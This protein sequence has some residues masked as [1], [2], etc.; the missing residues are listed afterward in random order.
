[1]KL[2]N[3]T[4]MTTLFTLQRRF[5]QGHRPKPKVVSGIEIAP[6]RNNAAA[7]FCV[8]ADFEMSWAWRTRGQ[9]GAEL[10][11]A[12]ERENVPVILRLLEEYSIPITW[13]T[14]G[15]L[16]LESC[17]RSSCG[18]P[19]ADM[20]R[21]AEDLY[22]TGDWYVHDPCSNVGKDP[23]WYAPDLVQQ[24]LECRVPQEIGTHSFSHINFSA[25]H[26]NAELVRRELE[27]CI[28]VMQQFGLKQ[29]SLVFPL[30]IVEYSYMP[31]LAELGITSLRH[32]DEKITLSYPERTSSGIYR[33]YETMSL[34]TTKHYDYV[35]KARIF[36]DKA[37][38]RQAAFSFWF[39]PSDPV[40]W[41]DTQFRPILDYVNSQ[42]QKGQL[43]VA[44]MQSVTA[45]CE[46]REQLQLRVEREQNRLS[47]EFSTAFD[48]QRY[49]ASELT[50]LIPA[51]SKPLT[52]LLRRS[53]GDS[54]PVSTETV[55]GGSPHLLV[56]IPTDAKVL[57]F[58]F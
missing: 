12:T 13:A 56:N 21:P 46:A 4:L 25:R 27:S 24:I 32:R 36:I 2:A 23:L 42:R 1:M 17:T 54:S 5:A 14:V 43:W 11:A 28:E 41:F 15:H 53:N 35:E 34:R 38:Q 40:E 3:P 31:L 33:F 39:H 47:I 45:Y 44:S 9:H 58:V 50:L 55:A 52:A 30:N 10:M 6:Y 22:W 49:G 48:K 8:S 19:H 7:A 18:L 16:L 51:R 57:E 20:P 29:R 37:I 26:S